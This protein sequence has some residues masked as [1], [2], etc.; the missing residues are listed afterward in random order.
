M[1]GTRIHKYRLTRDIKV[2]NIQNRLFHLDYISKIN[3]AFPGP[4][5]N[6]IDSMRIFALIPFGLPDTEFLIDTL[7]RQQYNPAD[8]GI[9]Y[10]YVSK[11]TG[12]THR[13]SDY[14][15]DKIMVDCMKM[16]YNIDY[17]GFTNP[18]EYQNIL[19]P[20]AKFKRELYTFNRSM[21]KFEH[22]IQIA[23]PGGGG[24]Q[25]FQY[26]SPIPFEE[27]RRLLELSLQ[28]DYDRSS[29]IVSLRDTGDIITN[30]NSI[31]RIPKSRKSKTRKLHRERKL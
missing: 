23:A 28:R 16:L 5:G 1:Y 31:Y 21:L 25:F 24:V 19:P 4:D 18:V 10:N 13:Y 17:E 26:K 6:G 30:N 9:I 2:I 7:I 11:I 14:D 27:R 20:D 15:V 29:R 12:N 3:V 8:L 22:E